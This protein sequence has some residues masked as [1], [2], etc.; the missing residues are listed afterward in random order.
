M[1]NQ[2]LWWGYK[3]LCNY[4]AYIEMYFTL[5]NLMNLF[6]IVSRAWRDK[7]QPVIV[8]T[9]SLC[10][11]TS[12]QSLDLSLKNLMKWMLSYAESGV[13]WVNYTIKGHVWTGDINLLSETPFLEGVML[14]LAKQ[15]RPPCLH[16]EANSKSKGCSVRLESEQRRTEASEPGRNILLILL[17]SAPAW[18]PNQCLWFHAVL[19]GTLPTL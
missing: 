1:K 15:G 10:Q 18:C 16:Q 9:W 2:R 7:V 5:M 14:V 8:L 13:V 19:T 11:N 6:I 4:S 3:V 17:L 12:A